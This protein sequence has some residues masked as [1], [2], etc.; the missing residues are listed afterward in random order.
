[1]VKSTNAWILKHILVFGENGQTNAFDAYYFVRRTDICQTHEAHAY[2]RS[3][4][5]FY[6]SEIYGY[7]LVFVK[8]IIEHHIFIL[9]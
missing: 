3:V 4:L 8:N 1:M 5:M 7:I 6:V 9:K 2:S